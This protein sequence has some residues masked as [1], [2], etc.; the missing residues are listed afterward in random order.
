MPGI[1]P[2]PTQ[3]RGHGPIGRGQGRRRRPKGLALRPTAGVTSYFTLKRAFDERTRSCEIS[4]AL[5]H[6]MGASI[7]RGVKRRLEKYGSVADLPT[8]QPCPE[9][10]LI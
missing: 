9:W 6:H 8:A 3:I 4:T 2:E 1:P 10:E 5:R 7:A